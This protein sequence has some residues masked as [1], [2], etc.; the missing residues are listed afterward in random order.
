MAGN[1]LEPRRWLQLGLGVVCMSMSAN[2]QYGWTLFV[3][4]MQKT[5]G[6]DRSAI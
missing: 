1:W 4:P 6:W 5:F 2:L 3:N